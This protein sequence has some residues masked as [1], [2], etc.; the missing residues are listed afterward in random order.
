VTT[1]GIVGTVIR[2]HQDRGR[3]QDH[4]RAEPHRPEVFGGRWVQI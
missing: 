2:A 4:G 1:G 3:D